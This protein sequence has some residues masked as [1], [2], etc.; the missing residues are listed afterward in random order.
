[1]NSNKLKYVRN[2]RGMSIS[3][4]ARRTNLSRITVS[5]IENGHSNP[6]V[7][8]VSSICK[9][10]GKNPNEIFFNTFVNHDEHKEVTK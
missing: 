7:T 3:E 2:K 9:A 10:L 1:M 8:T 6:T 4:L 5:K